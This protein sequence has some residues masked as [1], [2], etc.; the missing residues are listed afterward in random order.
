M[1]EIHFKSNRSLP[2]AACKPQGRRAG[3]DNTGT[4]KSITT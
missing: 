4:A 3:E 2:V 1:T